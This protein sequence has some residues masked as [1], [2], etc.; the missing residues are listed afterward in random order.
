ML[1]RF[2]YMK[3]KSNEQFRSISVNVITNWDLWLARSICHSNE[4][5]IKAMGRSMTDILPVFNCILLPPITQF[6]Y[7]TFVWPSTL[8]NATCRN[9]FY[10]TN[11]TITSWMSQFTSS[12]WHTSLNRAL[13]Y[14][15][16]NRITWVKCEART[17]QV[18]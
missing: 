15:T 16:N 13:N 6:G 8:R 14:A 9:G 18:P 17:L 10:F 5:L 7:L 2:S 1:F 3:L 4:I 12:K 11:T